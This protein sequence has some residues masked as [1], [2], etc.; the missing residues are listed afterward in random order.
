MR[1]VHSISHTLKKRARQIADLRWN[2]HWRADRRTPCGPWSEK[3]VDWTSSID[4]PGRTCVGL[5]EEEVGVTLRWVRCAH[6]NESEWKLVPFV[7]VQEMTTRG[8]LFFRIISP[9]GFPI[10]RKHAKTNAPRSSLENAPYRC[11]LKEAEMLDGNGRRWS[12]TT[13]VLN[14]E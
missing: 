13:V 4:V 6:R 14:G 8:I 2:S 9:C 12:L 1:R 10:V 3:E 11:T 5:W 7:G